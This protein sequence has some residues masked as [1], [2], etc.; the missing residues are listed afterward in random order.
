[1]TA[2]RDP[3]DEWGQGVLSQIETDGDDDAAFAEIRDGVAVDSRVNVGVLPHD[4]LSPQTKAPA[5]PSTDLPRF[6]VVAI[7][8]PPGPYAVR[9]RWLQYTLRRVATLDHAEALVREYEDDTEFPTTRLRDMES[10]EVR[11]VVPAGR[12]R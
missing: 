11:A 10:Y 5:A 12:T 2:A 9:D 4:P 1:M 6:Y 8:Y 7:D 3:S